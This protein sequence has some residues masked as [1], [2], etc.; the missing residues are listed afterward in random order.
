[1][2]NAARSRL[3]ILLVAMLCPLAASGDE[4]SLPVV[5]VRVAGAVPNPVR[6]DQLALAKLS[7]QSVRVKDRDGNES[8]YEG[9]PLHE[10]LEQAGVKFG[11][12]LRGPA[13]ASYLVVEAADGYRAVFALP[14]LDPASTDRVVLLAYRRDGKPLLGNEG[15]LRVVVPGEKRQSRW[16]RQVLT[17]RIGRS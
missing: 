11:N 6:L 12:D 14:E 10:V 17:L 3:P 13:L 15:P 9:T 8:T 4:E 5:A 16:V 2:G 7:R 1:M